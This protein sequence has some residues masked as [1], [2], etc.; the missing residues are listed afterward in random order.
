MMKFR[1]LL[2]VWCN[3]TNLIFTGCGGRFRGS[4]GRVAIDAGNDLASFEDKSLDDCKA[5]CMRTVGCM[6][7]EF[8]F[9]RRI[10]FTNCYL[11]DKTLTSS[12][13]FEGMGGWTTYY[14]SNSNWF[15]NNYAVWLIIWIKNVNLKLPICIFHD[16]RVRNK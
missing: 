6:N 8:H 15:L 1:L 12:D 4:S 16:F 11:K 14:C 3:I 13:K 10:G 5:L 9:Y 7:L 2:M